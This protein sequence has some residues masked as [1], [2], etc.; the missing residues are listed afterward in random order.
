VAR[1][2]HVVC[3]QNHDQVGNRALG[4][5]LSALAGFEQL[6]LAAATVL[7]SPFTPLLFMGEEYGETAPFQYFIDHGE[8]D[9][10]EAV[11]TGRREEFAGFAWRAE[12]PDPASEKTFEQ[13]KLQGVCSKEQ[14]TLWEFHAALIEVRK[15]VRCIL[16]NAKMRVQT[17]GQ[18][19][20]HALAVRYAA[21]EQEMLIWFNFSAS[22]SVLSIEHLR[23]EARLRLNSADEEWG[24]PGRCVPEILDPAAHR[25]IRMARWSTA[26]YLI[27]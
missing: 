17:T 22:E 1:A 5:R 10:V 25:E 15:T 20:Q 7:L 2:R 16:A 21:D 27:T 13:S 24:G 3:A 23:L 8:P 9:L 11:R 6:K 19:E 14:A 12:I 4:E 18:A 26:V